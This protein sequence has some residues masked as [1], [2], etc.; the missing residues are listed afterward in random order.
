MEPRLRQHLV[1]RSRRRRRLEGRGAAPLP[2]RSCLTG[3]ASALICS[4]VRLIGSGLWACRYSRTPCLGGRGP[5]NRLR[6]QHLILRSRR[7]R[8]LEGRGAALPSARSCLTGQASALTSVLLAF[9]RAGRLR[10]ACIPVP[11]VLM[12]GRSWNRLRPQHLILRSHRRWRL[13][14]RGAA[15]PSAHC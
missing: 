5:W 10:P 2:A 7:R 15:L 9:D 14:G 11:L 8:R 1:L 3:Q 13:E 12:A 6:R 4:L